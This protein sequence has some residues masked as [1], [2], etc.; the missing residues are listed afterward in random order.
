MP[1]PLCHSVSAVVQLVMGVHSLENYHML[2]ENT[3][4]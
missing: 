2:M 3:E 1:F 4:V